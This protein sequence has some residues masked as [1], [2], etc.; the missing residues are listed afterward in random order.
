L[1]GKIRF[2][3]GRTPLS[4]RESR[5]LAEHRLGRLATASLRGRPHV[6]PVTYE[7]DGERV[8]IGGW[9]LEKSLKY[10][11]IEMNPNVAFV[12]DDYA[13]ERSRRGRGIEVRGVAECLVEDGAPYISIRIVSKHSWGLTGRE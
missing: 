2:D 11:M 5:Y 10:R 1:R 13:S 3:D 12:V 9:N 6:V 8:N 4:R 7:F